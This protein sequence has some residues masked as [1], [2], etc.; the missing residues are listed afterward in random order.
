[1]RLF[2][3]FNRSHDHFR[4]T[5]LHVWMLIGESR[6]NV[7]VRV[8]SGSGSG[9]GSGLGSGLGLGSGSGSGSTAF[10]LKLCRFF[11]LLFA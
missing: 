2:L 4:R 1:M 11:D 10:F 3:S 5:V 7:R 9:S 6:I 8:R